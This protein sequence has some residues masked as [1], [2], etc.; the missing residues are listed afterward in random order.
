MAWLKIDDGFVEHEKVMGL[1][2]RAFRLHMTALCQCAKNLTDGLVDP[3]RLRI[4]AAIVGRPIPA[5]VK[6]L[7]EAGLWAPDGDCYRI[8]DY[9]EYNP[10]AVKVKKERENAKERMRSA[11]AARSGEHRAERSAEQDGNG[12]GERSG[13]PSRPVPNARTDTV[14]QESSKGR[15][16]LRPDAAA[17]VLPITHEHQLTRLLRAIGLHGDIGTEQILRSAVVGLPEGS[18]AKVCESVETQRN[19]KDRAAYA[20]AALQ[21]EHLE[22]GSRP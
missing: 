13:T 3:S 7:V 14:S 10:P 12:V 11:R 1:S 5:S 22:Q 9:L 21:S 8:N 19:I 17:E 15:P 18:L 4:V 16:S 2:D 6:E 20:V